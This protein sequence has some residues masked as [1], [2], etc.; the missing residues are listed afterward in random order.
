MLP[1][2]RQKTVAN[3]IKSGYIID[4]YRDDK[5]ILIYILYIFIEPVY[6]K[7]MCVKSE[8]SEI[9]QLFVIGKTK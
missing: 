6:I 3:Q 9:Y 1:Y 2:I 7:A 5:G 4:R 8:K